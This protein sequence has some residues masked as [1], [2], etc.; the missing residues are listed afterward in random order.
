MNGATVLAKALKAQG[1]EY[2]FGIVGIPV[3]EVGMAMQM[4]GITYIGMRNEQAA[5]YAAGVVGYMTGRPGVCLAV[6]GPGVIHTIAGLSNAWS[7]CW[8]MI[9]IGGSSDKSQAEMGAFQECPQVESCRPYCKMASQF[10]SVEQ[11]PNIVEKAVKTSISGRPGAVYLDIPGDL[12]NT[13]V[14]EEDVV[15]TAQVPAPPL[16]F[17]DPH[18]ISTALEALAT[19]QR[20]LV[21]VGKGAAAA[22]AEKEVREFIEKTQLPF[23][24]TPMG[25]GVVP[26]DHPLSCSPARSTALKNAD[27]IVLLG[28]R[29]NWIL[30][31]G[32]PPRFAPDVKIIQVEI[33]PEELHTNV[34]AHV[35]LLGHIKA[36]V[37]QLNQALSARPWKFASNAAWRTV[38][39]E[40]IEANRVNTEKLMASDAV[41]MSY[42]RVFKEVRAQIPRDAIIVSEGANTMDIGR[43][44][45][46][47]FLPRH[48]LDAGTF[49]TMGVGFGFAIAAA[50]VHPEKKVIAV[51]GD[52]AF[53][54]SAMEFEV[55]ARYKLPIVFL[56]VNNGGIYQGTGTEGPE[57]PFDNPVTALTYETRYEKM[58]AAFG[59]KGYYVKTPQEL[60]AAFADAMKQSMPTIVNV[61]IDAYGTRKAQEFDWLTRGSKL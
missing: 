35:P 8:P 55:A 22:H 27:V 49:G 16:T 19:A 13:T 56:I 53:G 60:T 44:L 33:C 25:K 10:P 2:A 6:S 3:I 30:H 26:D 37:S 61:M 48:R 58:A 28:A 21:I 40:K 7:N 11:I 4:E 39:A 31:F 12:V 1:V 51:E 15:F 18:G 14:E 43:T 9:V 42:Y 54:F 34:R 59:G 17:A 57:N 32:L 23:L 50:V 36:V 29:L 24:P 46:P 38:L 41:P 52:S 47:N 5:S 45:I 20:P